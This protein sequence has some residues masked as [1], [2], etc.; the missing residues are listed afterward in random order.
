MKT[1]A[2]GL[3]RPAQAGGPAPRQATEIFIK[4][5]AMGF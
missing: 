4:L 1:R 2:A 5:R 3:G